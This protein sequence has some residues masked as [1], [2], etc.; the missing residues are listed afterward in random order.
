MNPDSP[1]HK[2]SERGTI[3]WMAR[4][5]LAANL[6][7]VILLGGGLWTAV[8]IQKEVFP[9]FQLDIVQVSVSYP[10]A[11]PSEVEQGILRPVEEAVRGVEGIREITSEAREGRGTVSI[12]LIGGVDRMKSFQDIDQAVQRIRTFP[13]DIEEPEVSLRDR[14]REVM[15]VGL[16]GGDD[17]WMLR[18]LAERLR[19]QLLA[20]DNITQVDIGRVP[21]YITH[22]EIPR[23]KLREYGLT[24]P[25]VAA[26]IRASSEDVAAGAVETNAGEILLRVKARKQWADEF[27][28]VEVVSSSEGTAVT[29]GDIAEI[30]DGFDETGFHSQFNQQKSVELNIYR[31]G[32]QSPMDVAEAVE[33]TMADFELSLPPGVQWRI[34]SNNAEDF[35]RR[36]SLVVENGLMALVIVLL[37][38][39]LFLEFRL[40]FWVMMGMTISFI[41]G[42]MVL[43]VVGVSINMIS[44]FGFL[45]VLGI[46]VD[47]AIVV[48]ENIYDK[49]LEEP[50]RLKAA[51]VGAREMAG[52]VTFSILTN[53]VAFI[54]LLFIPGETGKFWGPL[55]VV[56]IVVL[57]VSLFEALYILPAHLAHTRRAG[58][59]GGIGARLHGGQ[60]VFSRGFTRFVHI[61]YAPILAVCL[62]YRYVTATAA[63]ALFVIVGGYATSA[64]MGMILMPEV[65]ADEIE[66]G[67]RL[68]VGTTPDQATHVA[69]EITQ[70]TRKMFDEHNLDRVAEGIKTNVR[71]GNFIDVEIVMKP[72]T[73]RDMTANEVISLWRDSIGD[74]AGV[75]RITF[76]A[77][78]GPGGFRPDISVDLSHSDIDVLEKASRAFLGS[79]ERFSNT[80]DV[81]DNY[82]KGKTQYDFYL[83]PEGKALGLTDEELGRQLRG[84]FY[85]SLAL[86]LLRG[87]NEIEVRVKLPKEQR[88]DVHNL[89]DLVIRTPGGTEV[90]L[91]DVATLIRTEAFTSINRRGGRRIV[92]VSMDVEPKRATG[93]VITALNSETL[94]QLRA[95]YPGITWTFE[96]SD[97]ELRKATASLWGGFGLAMA[98][99]YALLAIAFGSYL[100]PLIVLTAI[101]FG[102][103]GAVVGH[104]ILGYDLSLISFM[105]VIALS[106]V[107]VNDSLIMI[108]FANRKR[109]EGSAYDAIH[110]A[111][112]RR[113]RPIMLTT[114]TTFGGLMPIIFE[115]SMQAQYIIPMAISLG[116]GI[117]FATAII[118]LLVPCLYLVLEDLKRIVTFLYPPESPVVAERV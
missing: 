117:V 42:I 50:D 66:A 59:S 52:P 55:P 48:G 74:I 40:A 21:D 115:T 51:V 99:V 88:Q 77:E 72:P 36:V 54:P 109:R 90:P 114:V 28:K 34:D 102:I 49:R 73:E 98:I 71:R 9:E 57:A 79:V 95:D 76:E 44:L 63:I 100:Q 1:E 8:S 86:R 75:D 30:R 58:R 62:R 35:R 37:I 31:V 41:G 12:E 65:S 29:L 89:E 56:V 27:S 6:L 87:T 10:G 78:R 107:V 22:I 4:N 13:D 110:Q 23:N 101:P 33:K 17:A 24:L 82:N 80:R 68:P 64:H 94:P 45:V 118:L 19:D 113:F 111:G 105:G 3:A 104:M 67:V 106:G 38:L 108:D 116:F 85:G 103:V 18:K 92:N 47:D 15:E 32:S 11:A 20:D 53:I 70:A 26:I 81:N 69:E 96:G 16:Y 91:L 83:R 46:V 112:L 93:Q 5:S 25:D 61:F 39:A 7:M 97:A 60:Q 43:P 2:D 14:Q 84:A